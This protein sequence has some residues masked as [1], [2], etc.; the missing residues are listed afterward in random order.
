MLDHCWLKLLRSGY[1]LTGRVSDDDMR[2][3]EVVT[4]AVGAFWNGGCDQ[5]SKSVLFN[6]V[7]MLSAFDEVSLCDLWEHGDDLLSDSRSSARCPRL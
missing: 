2:E 6:L 1:C 4:P 5:V 7:D 3:A